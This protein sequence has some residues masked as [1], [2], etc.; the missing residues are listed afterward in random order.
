M[1]GSL[2]EVCSSLNGLGEWRKGGEMAGAGAC[3]V[4]GGLAKCGGAAGHG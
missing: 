1:F 3:A 2:I 4:R